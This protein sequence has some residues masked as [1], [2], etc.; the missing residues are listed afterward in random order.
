MLQKTKTSK[1]KIPFISGNVK[2]ASYISQKNKKQIH[3][4]NISYTSENGNQQKIFY[5]FSNVKAALIF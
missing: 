2:K 4:K 1:K 5:I 3:P